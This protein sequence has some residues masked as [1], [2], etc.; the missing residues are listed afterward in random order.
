MLRIV[1]A[2]IKLVRGPFK[3]ATLI[4]DTLNLAV[5]PKAM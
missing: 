4:T 5:S 2:V 3:Q 1:A